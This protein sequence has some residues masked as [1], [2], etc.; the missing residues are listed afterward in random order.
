M[1]GQD[2]DDFNSISVN[3]TITENENLSHVSVFDLGDDA[4]RHRRF[5]QQ[6]CGLEHLSGERRRH[7]CGIAGDVQAGRLKI[8]EGVKCP[9]Y[10]SHFAIF[11]RASS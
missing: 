9:F 3:D 4:A 7:R 8:I 6:V 10:F 5:R 2:L 11:A 1:N